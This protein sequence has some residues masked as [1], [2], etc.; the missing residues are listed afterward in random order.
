MGGISFI[1]L[2]VT[3]MIM[4]MWVRR[5]SKN[6]VFAFFFEP[7]RE[8]TTELLIIEKGDN[9]PDKVRSKIDGGDYVIHPS[10]MFWHSWPPGFP[11]WVKEPIPTSLFV[12]NRPEPVDPSSQRSIVTAR[13]IR[14]MTDEAMLKQTWQD[15]HDAI[16]E[17]RGLSK[18]NLAMYIAGG[19][20]LGIVAVGYLAWIVLG[21]VESIA[22]VI[23][24]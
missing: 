3:S 9:S 6:K 1:L 15:A 18:S 5:S 14:Y 7:N 21:K 4:I 2:A 11:N 22:K 20:L 23:G 10:K 19:S 13:A 16:G 17:T 8:F 24:V 12:R